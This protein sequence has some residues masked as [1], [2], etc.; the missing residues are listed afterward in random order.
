MLGAQQHRRWSTRAYASGDTADGALS[1][2]TAGVQPISANGCTS[3]SC[4]YRT[5]NGDD[6]GQVLWFSATVNNAPA[7]GVAWSSERTGI[8]GLAFE[9]GRD[10]STLVNWWNQDSGPN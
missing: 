7:V 1:T 10:V 6:Q 4:S 3:G 9:Q 5:S 8:V 2:L